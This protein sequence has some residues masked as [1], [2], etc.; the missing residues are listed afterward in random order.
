LAEVEPIEAG[1]AQALTKGLPADSPDVAALIRR[2]HT[3]IGR[4]WNDPPNRTAFIGLAKIYQAHPDFRSRY[5]N[6]TTGL[7]DYLA[8][9]IGAFAERELA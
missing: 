6:R 1:L 8:K 9:A 7:T 3:W 4:A 2:L 5:E